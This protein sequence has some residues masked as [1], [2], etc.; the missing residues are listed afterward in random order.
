MKDRQTTNRYD[1]IVDNIYTDFSKALDNINYTII[2][3][4]LK[5]E[6]FGERILSWFGSFLLEFR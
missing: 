1:Q 3:A 4:K 5:A 6:G 2:L